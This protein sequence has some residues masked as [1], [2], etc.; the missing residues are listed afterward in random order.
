[1]RGGGLD[2]WDHTKTSERRQK[3]HLLGVL[4]IRGGLGGG[5]F[6][7]GVGSPGVP[8]TVRGGSRQEVELYKASH[9]DKLGL[10]V[11]YRTDG[12]EDA[13]IYVGEVRGGLGGGL[14][15]QGWGLMG[16]LGSP[17]GAWGV[18]GGPNGAGGGAPSVLG[19]AADLHVRVPPHPQVNP[20]SIAAKDGRIREGDRIIQVGFFLGGGH[21]WGPGKGVGVSLGIPV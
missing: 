13:G 6:W 16:W 10:T 2:A 19:G 12:E 14:G 8:L 7:G 11:C 15:P 17:V 9:R 18:S 5:V 4:R 21:L 20:N 1:M 3:T